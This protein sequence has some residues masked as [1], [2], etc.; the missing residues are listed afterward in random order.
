[1]YLLPV[2]RDHSRQSPGS[3][4]ISAALETVYSL[5]LSLLPLHGLISS[6]LQNT[7]GTGGL[8]QDV[9]GQWKNSHVTTA[10]GKAPR[11]RVTGFTHLLVTFTDSHSPK[12]LP[13]PLGCSVL[14][15]FLYPDPHLPQNR[16]QHPN[17]N[18]C[19]SFPK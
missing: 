1:M 11:L 4:P 3:Q 18:S 2:S 8:F 17:C 14:F 13:S 6:R 9:F 10:P 16:F 19:D 12:L 15:Y 5:P 7:N